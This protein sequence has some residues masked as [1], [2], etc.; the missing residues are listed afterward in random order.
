VSHQFDRDFLQRPLWPRRHDAAA[1]VGEYAS[2]SQFS[3]SA[4]VS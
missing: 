4:L 2:D 3:S 1:F